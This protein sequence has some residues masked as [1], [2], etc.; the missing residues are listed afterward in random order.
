[1]IKQQYSSEQLLTRW[2]DRRA[3]QNI[4][5]KF[6]HSYVIHEEELIYDRFWS[7]RDDVCLGFNEGWYNG[8]EAVKG[9]YDALGEKKKLAS[10]LIRDRFPEELA[11]Y[12]EEECA[13]VGILGYKPVDTCV[14]EVAG[15][16]ETAKGLWICRGASMDLTSCGFVLNTE[17]SY[18]AIDFIKEADGWKIW[19]M[20]NVFDVLTPM[21]YGWAGEPTDFTE[22]PEFA[23]L[24]D[25]KMPE[26]NVPMK[27]REYYHPMREFSPSPMPP[28]PYYDFSETFT[29]GIEEV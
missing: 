29:Y 20:K 28:E 23:P 22:A 26:P 6:S 4:A 21:G 3:C 2:E 17:W 13:G 5:G 25:F 8:A 14:L 24:K 9:Y 11:Q 7:K 19:H 16:G 15:N 1:M 18:L 10:K 12:S 27:L